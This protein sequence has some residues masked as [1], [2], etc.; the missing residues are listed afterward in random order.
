[1]TDL[2]AV[3]AAYG[4]QACSSSGP[5]QTLNSDDARGDGND[6]K[7]K[8]HHQRREDSAQRRLG[9]DIAITNGGHGHDRPIDP[10]GNATELTFG[11]KTD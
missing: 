5:T 3:N 7:A 9:H 6:P 8:Q 4:P 11:V 1:M 10:L 2:T